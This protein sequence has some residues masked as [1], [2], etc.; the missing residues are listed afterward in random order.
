MRILGFG[1]RVGI[2]VS[3]VKDGYFG[4]WGLS[5]VF[6]GVRIQGLYGAK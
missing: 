1:F 4:V 3:G 2:L 5:W 6:F